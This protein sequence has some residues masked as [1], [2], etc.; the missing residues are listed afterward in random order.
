MGGRSAM[1][2]RNLREI[3]IRDKPINTR[4][5]VSWLSGKALKLLPPDVTFLRL[6]CTKFDSCCLSVCVLEFDT[7]GDRRGGGWALGQKKASASVIHAIL[8]GSTATSAS[9][10]MLIP[11]VS[12]SPFLPCY[13]RTFFVA[14]TMKWHSLNPNQTKHTEQNKACLT[15]LPLATVSVWPVGPNAQCELPFNCAL[16]MLTG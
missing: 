2:H 15:Q 9:I 4:N 3:K 14:N 1:L 5:L 10:A 7:Y 8:F 16:E 6:K 13:F 12:C 11:A